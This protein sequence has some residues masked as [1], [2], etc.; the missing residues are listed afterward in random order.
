MADMRAPPLHPA[1]LPPGTQVG[2]WRVVGWRG[3]GTYGAVYRAVEIGREQAEPVALKLAVHRKDPRFERE[4]ALLSRI[5]HPNVPALRAH[6]QWRSTEGTYPYLVMQWVEGVPLYE[7]AAV[8][9]PT[10]R[11]ALRVLAQ[12]ARALAATHQVG[13]VHRDMKGDNVLVCAD[14]QPFLVDF[15]SSTH[16]GASLLTFETL[17]PGT[18]TYRTPEAWRFSLK[19]RHLLMAHYPAE[20]F[21]DVFALGVTAHRLV[22]DEYPPPTD[23]GAKESLLWYA[24]KVNLRP[25]LALNPRVDPELSALIL[26]MLSVQPEARGTTSE[27]AGLLEQRAERAGPQADQRLFAWETLEPSAWS[28]ED[29][30]AASDLGHRPRHRV[31]EVVRQAEQRDAA[32]RAAKERREA[33]ERARTLAP[34]QPNPP[35]ERER[36]FQPWMASAAVVLLIGGAYW[37]ASQLPPVRFPDGAQAE[38]RD[39]GVVELA[40]E[41]LTAPVSEEELP[42]GLASISLDLPPDPLPGQRRPGKKGKC[43]RPGEWVINGGCWVR[44]ADVAPPC[45]DGEFEWMGSCYKPAYVTSRQPTSTPREPGRDAQ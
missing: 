20:P 1:E 29:A 35:P 5:R 28:R 9:N 38:G 45:A 16:A 14:G 41:A 19:Y 40:Q 39:G 21:D 30:A 18:P 34:T 3:R 6:G 22:T 13:G 7:W 4:V 43:Q 26:R 2:T 10:N 24:D 42:Q 25:P 33:E 15:G 44:Q 17:P 27:L 8:H 12:V 11:E 23:P 36:R 32:E 31:R 37:I